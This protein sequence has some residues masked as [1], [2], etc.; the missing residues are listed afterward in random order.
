M[1]TDENKKYLLIVGHRRYASFKKLGLQKIKAIVRETDEYVNLPLDCVILRENTRLR[2]EEDLTSFMENIKANGQIHPIVVSENVD[3]LEDDWLALNMAENFNRKDYSPLEAAE[4][5]TRFREQGLSFS[6]I[7][8]RTGIPLT[9]IKTYMALIKRTPVEFLK[10]IR[11]M[12]PKDASNKKGKLS[13]AVANA[14]STMRIPN[15]K[16]NILLMYKHAKKE[17]WSKDQIGT[18]TDILNQGVPFE[19]AIKEIDKWASKTVSFVVNKEINKTLDIPMSRYVIEVLK[20]KRPPMK[21]L[22]R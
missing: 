18:I 20:G 5:V 17:E 15:E 7:A 16:K 19:E 14:I 1:M 22:L 21:D 6:E 12:S 8:S 2:T 11:N 9:T 3:M 13:V 4:G 10:E